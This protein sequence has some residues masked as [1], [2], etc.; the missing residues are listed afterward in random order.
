MSAS[1]SR[2]N[3]RE[4]LQR[5]AI[6]GVGALSWRALGPGIGAFADVTPR[7]RSLTSPRVGSTAYGAYSGPVGGQDLMAALLDFESKVGRKVGVYRMYRQWTD[8]IRCTFTDQLVARG[9]TLYV[10]NH[11]WTNGGKTP[12]LW[13]DIAA[14]KQ[15][16]RI[17][18]LASE[19][20]AL[21]KPMYYCFHHEPE[22]DATG[23]PGGQSECGTAADFVAAT[24]RVW[25]VFAAQHVTNVT[26]VVTL[27]AATYNGE[28]G[29][30]ADH[31][32]P[33][34]G[35]YL[36]GVDGYNRAQCYG[37]G[38]WKDFTTIFDKAH[39]Y[40]AKAGRKLFVGEAG[41]VEGGACGGKYGPSAKAGWFSDALSVLKGWP[42]VEAFLY[43]HV[44]SDAPYR[45]DTSTNSLAAFKVI[46]KD[47]YFIL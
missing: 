34:S 16:A 9:T 25:N 11:A 17:V 41:C 35:P 26:F 29:P 27:M 47:P 2:L 23:S 42:D 43:S 32:L 22:D 37:K 33:T 36:C 10:S 14:G 13:A 39:S 31:W 7:P 3:R 45:V 15:D 8:P 20:K 44:T 1:S 28:Y 5:M 46:A 24:Q 6:A 21:A 30:T 38:Y 12:V 40:A 18:Q 4:L 19:C